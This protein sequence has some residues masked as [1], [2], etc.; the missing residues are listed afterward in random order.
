MQY[1][2]F[3]CINHEDLSGTHPAFGNDVL[4]LV[5][6]GAY[7]RCERDKPIVGSDPA[8]RPQ[9]VAIQQT[10]SVPPISEHNARR[11][12]PRL[13]VHGVVLIERLEIGV[14]AFDILPSRRNEHAQRARQLD[15]TGA[16]QLQH[17]VET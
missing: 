9:A 6:M 12:V 17:V 7:F 3:N 4:G 1:L 8:R 14:D 13:H 10:A 5:S 15:A 16:Q 11:A 2:A